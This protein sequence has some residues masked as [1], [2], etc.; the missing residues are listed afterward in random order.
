MI[1]SYEEILISSYLITS[2]FKKIKNGNHELKSKKRKFYLAVLVCI[3]T[4]IRSPL[5]LYFHNQDL[6]RTYQNVSKVSTEEK[7]SKSGQ[8][9]VQFILGDYLMKLG[10]SG[11][12]VHIWWTAYSIAIIVFRQGEY[13][14]FMYFNRLILYFNTFFSV[15]YYI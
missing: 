11:A 13:R 3:L 10:N 4:L 12:I 9:V 7:S 5:V 1:H 8:F 6:E 15:F 2:N 14:I